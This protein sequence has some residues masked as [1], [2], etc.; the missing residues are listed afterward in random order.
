MAILPFRKSVHRVRA[1]PIAP[2]HTR[3]RTTGSGGGQ[4]PTTPFGAPTSLA[5]A[6]PRGR[7]LSP[8]RPPREPQTSPHHRTF[9]R[10]SPPPSSACLRGQTP[11]PTLC[12]DPTPLCPRLC[13]LAD[14]PR[15]RSSLPRPRPSGWLLFFCYR[16]ESPFCLSARHT[17]RSRPSTTAGALQ[18]PPPSLL[19]LVPSTGGRSVGWSAGGQLEDVLARDAI[20]SKLPS[21]PHCGLSS[22]QA[23]P[24]SDASCAGGR[25]GL[26][27]RCRHCKHEP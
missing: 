26:H 25:S 17:P 21:T 5:R 6:S 7:R 15:I 3:P 16:N 4:A 22:P 13:R 18:P 10:G 12:R 9:Q 11:P 23:P 19:A 1:V 24:R 27:F 8:P 20:R 2:C 14:R